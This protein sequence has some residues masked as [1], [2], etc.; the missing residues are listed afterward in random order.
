[1]GSDDE[2]SQSE[3]YEGSVATASTMLDSV[4]VDVSGAAVA[5]LRCKLCASI[6]TELSPL[7]LSADLNPSYLEWRQY[8]KRKVQ[9]RVVAKAPR[10]KLCNWCAKTFLC[11]AVGR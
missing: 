6:A 5:G 11:F 1:M 9:G 8:S 10:S 4:P 3:D 7:A 2:Q